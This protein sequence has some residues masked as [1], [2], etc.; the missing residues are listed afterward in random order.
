METGRCWGVWGR[1]NA[2]R[3]QGERV[4][5]EITE[6]QRVQLRRINDRA[7]V[8]HARRYR[9]QTRRGRALR[10]ARKRR[11]DPYSFRVRHLSPQ[12]ARRVL[13]ACDEENTKGHDHPTT[14]WV[15]G[16]EGESSPSRTTATYR[17]TR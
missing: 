5:I 17:P 13:E 4:E 6:A 1:S 11:S 15:P 12:D 14:R 16:A 3:Y 7:R 8:A 10:Y 2:P 9:Y